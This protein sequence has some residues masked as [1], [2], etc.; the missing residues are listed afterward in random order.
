MRLIHYSDSFDATQ[1]NIAVLRE[2]DTLSP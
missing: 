1:S 2:G